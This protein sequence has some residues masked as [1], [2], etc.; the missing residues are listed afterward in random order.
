LMVT[1]QGGEDVR[2]LQGVHPRRA[3]LAQHSGWASRTC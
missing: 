1:A 3:E 2:Q